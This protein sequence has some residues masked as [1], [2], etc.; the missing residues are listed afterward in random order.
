MGNCGGKRV[1]IGL[2]GRGSDVLVAV[3]WKCNNRPRVFSVK[4]NLNR[5]LWRHTH[6]KCNPEDTHYRPALKCIEPFMGGGRHSRVTGNLV[7]QA[8]GKA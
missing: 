3:T 8:P 4:C 7:T 2:G 5:Y 6:E 1:K